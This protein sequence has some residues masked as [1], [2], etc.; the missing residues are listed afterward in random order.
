MI[1]QAV[2]FMPGAQSQVTMPLPSMVLCME[3]AT[4]QESLSRTVSFTVPQLSQLLSHDAGWNAEAAGF[5]PTKCHQYHHHGGRK[6]DW[7][8][9]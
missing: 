9:Q 8:L 2:T 6:I 5:P 1:T 7:I 4:F 3:D